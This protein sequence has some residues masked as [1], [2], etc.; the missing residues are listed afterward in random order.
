MAVGTLLGFDDG[1]ESAVGHAGAVK[2]HGAFLADLGYAGIGEDL[3]IDLVAVGAGFEDGV[4]EDDGL[5][6]VGSGEGGK[7]DETFLGLEGLA[8]A[9]AV[10]EGAVLSPDGGGLAGHGAVGFYFVL[11]DGEDESV[12]VFGHG[13][14]VL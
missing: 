13:V 8:E 5:A 7:G 4:G 3:G 1:L 2:G 10:L 14:W 11:G 6:G 9:F 12:D